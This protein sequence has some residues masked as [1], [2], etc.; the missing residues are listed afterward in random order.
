MEARTI[1]VDVTARGDVPDTATERAR[2][3]VA[4]LAGTVKGPVLGARVVLT[5]ERNPRQ[6]RPA[7]AEGEVDLAGHRV[8]ARV[9][10]P[11]MPAAVDALADHLR[12]QLQRFADRVQDG[13]RRG[14]EAAPGEWFRGAWSPPRP[15]YLPRPP[16]ER[17]IIRRKSFA[18]A[19]QTI[20][21]AVADMAALDHDFFLFCD[22][23]TDC[24]A[25]IYRRDDGGLG[26]IAPYESAPRADDAGI[27]H[28]P[29]RYSEPLDLEAARSQM[30][31]LDHRFLF[32]VNAATGRG[33][34]LYLRYDGHY[35]LI[36]PAA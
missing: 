23:A 28:E 15:E 1:H 18:L 13:A 29:S 20:P 27:V 12:D 3:R 9:A 7:R 30:D 36:E 5:A 2:D 4:A 22:A 24:D 21:Q 31:A 19:S 32:F 34:V 33:A 25:V 8:R 16:A 26:V 14:A 11:T 6:A 35:G 17:E 10:A